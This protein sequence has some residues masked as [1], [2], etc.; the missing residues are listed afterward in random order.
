VAALTWPCEDRGYDLVLGLRRHRDWTALRPRA[1][2]AAV[3]GLRRTYAVTVADTDPDLEGE[4]QTGS[5]DVEDRNV[6]ARHLTSTAD[7][8]LVTATPTVVGVHRLVRTLGDLLELGVAGDRVLPV[9]N[10]APRSPRARAEVTRAVADLLGPPGQA[11][12]ASPLFIPARRELDGLHRDVAT[13]PK[14]I[15]AP[16]ARAVAALLERVD[17]ADDD[18][19]GT[20]PEPVPITPGSLGEGWS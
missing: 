13:L 10:R 16:L 2:E 14:A 17:Q 19:P 8:V 20:P 7:V 9:V 11:L 1:V 5:F 18:E 4:A 12:T 3:G 6:L 15:G